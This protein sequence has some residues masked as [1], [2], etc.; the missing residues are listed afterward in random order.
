MG[1]EL[2]K[3]LVIMRRYDVREQRNPE[4]GKAK[5][6]DDLVENGHQP[7]Q[8]PQLAPGFSVIRTYICRDMNINIILIGFSL[9]CYQNSL[10]GV[11]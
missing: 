5:W 6:V 11:A 2:L 3:D 4:E 8:K 9:T 10:H 7:R 1:L